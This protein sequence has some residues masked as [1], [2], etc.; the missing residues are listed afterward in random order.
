MEKTAK[1]MH[2]VYVTYKR[3]KIEVGSKDKN[4]FIP[5]FITAV[6]ILTVISLVYL[7]IDWLKLISRIPD[8]GNVFWELAHFEFSKMDLIIDALLET[9][10]I[11]TLSLIY[12]LLMGVFFGM[13]GSRNIVRAKGVAVFVQ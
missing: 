7:K 9:I 13:L 5:R 12:S 1:Q 2:G 11:A 10:S 4:R 3:G 8:I 6:V